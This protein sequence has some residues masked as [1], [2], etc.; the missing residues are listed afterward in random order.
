MPRILVAMIV[1]ASGCFFD[2]SYSNN[3]RCSDGKCPSGL[4]CW[5]NACVSMIPIDMAI[6]VPPEGLPAALTCADPGVF[7]ATGGTI[8][9][10]TAGATSKM[11]SSCGGFVMNGPD[12]VYRIM[13]NGT[14]QLRVSIDAGQRKAYVLATCVEAPSTPVCLGNARALMG[15]PVTVTPAN[16]PAFVVV[17]DENAAASGSYTLRLD[18]L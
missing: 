12:R 1:F 6:D 15:S 10:T 3:V 18:V 8:S 13:M 5:E 4:T 9:A 11:A 14:N 7:A 16:G 2:A 17:D